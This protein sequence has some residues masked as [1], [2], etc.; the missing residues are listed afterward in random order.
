MRKS[1]HKC[2]GSD[3]GSGKGSDIGTTYTISSR[4]M[5]GLSQSLG[6]KESGHLILRGFSSGL[7]AFALVHLFFGWL[8]LKLNL[9]KLLLPGLGL[10]QG[11]INKVVVKGFLC[12]GNKSYK[13]VQVP[14]PSL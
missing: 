12:L 8:E 2:G 5:R 11:P 3:G 14:I 6:G 7:L 4:G 9:L 1:F 13:V 10:I